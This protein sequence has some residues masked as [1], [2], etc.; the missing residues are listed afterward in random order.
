MLIVCTVLIVGVRANL[1]S[2]DLMKDVASQGHRFQPRCMKITLTGCSLLLE[3][4]GVSKNGWPDAISSKL[5]GPPKA[6]SSIRES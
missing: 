1:D 2:T 6:K 5:S 4:G 3:A